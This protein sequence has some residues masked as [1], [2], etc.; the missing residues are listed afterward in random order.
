MDHFFISYSS[1]DG[2]ELAVKL[3]DSLVAGPPSVPI[4]IDVRHL[5]TGEDWDEQI[6]EAI[7]TC[8]GF[9]FVMT[10]DSVTPT[11]VCKNEWTRALKY[12]KPIL[13]LH[14]SPDAELPF[15]LGSRQF[16][17]F[18]SSFDTAIARLRNHLAWIDSAEGQ[19]VALQYRLA[20][21]QRDLPRASPEQRPRVEQDIADLTRQITQH[22][23]ALD[24]PKA[25]QQRVQ[26]SIEGGLASVRDAAPPK[27]AVERNRIINP[28]PLV[29]PGWF[30]DRLLETKMIGDFLKDDSLRLMTIVGRGGI[31]K[32]AVV[33]RLLRA[34]E[35]GR[36]P[37]DG[38]HWAVDGIVYLSA[39]RSHHRVTVP[40]LYA[41]LTRLLPA[42]VTKQLDT[43]HGSGA[44]TRTTVQALAE[45]FSSTKVVVLLD[46]FED[47]MAIETGRIKDVDVD[48]CLR[49]LL[50]LPPHGIKVIVTTRVALAEIAL[51]EPAR[52]RRLDLDTGL[53]HPFG[54]ALLREMDVDGK[55]GLREAPD[56]LLSSARER[57]RGYPRALEHLYGILSADRSSSLAELLADT[58]GL[59]P[60]R[61][62][63][64]L[65]GEAF[66]RLDPAAQR[67]VQALS[68]YSNPVPT[69]AVDFL[70]QPYPPAI[71]AGPTLSR[72]VNMQ[73]VKKDA[74]GFYLHQVDR[75]HA[76]ARLPQDGIFSRKDLQLRAADWFTMARKPYTT[77]SS[78]DDISAVLSEF[79]LRMACG[80]Y[81]RAAE[82]A[83]QLATYLSLWG[84]NRLLV[85]LLER[86]RETPV[87][88]FL[89]F[90]TNIFL[91]L[92]YERLSELDRA[93]ICQTTALRIA[94]ERQNKAEEL[95]A[96][97]N[98]GLLASRQGRKAEAVELLKQ[99]L[100]IAVET[101]S[102][103]SEAIALSSLAKEFRDVGNYIEALDY[104]NRA[105]AIDREHRRFENLSIGLQNLA[106]MFIELGRYDNA[107]RCCTESLH[108]G[109]LAHSRA[110]Q[111]A[112]LSSLGDLYLRTDRLDQAVD[113]FRQSVGIADDIELFQFQIGGRLDLS[114]VHLI[115]GNIEAARALLL[116]CLPWPQAEASWINYALGVVALMQGRREDAREKFLNELS[117]ADRLLTLSPKS[118]SYMGRRAMTLCGLACC[119]V[120]D[121]EEARQAYLACLSP[122]RRGD[123][124]Y[125]LLLLNLLSKTAGGGV[126]S[127][128]VQMLEEAKT[129]SAS[130]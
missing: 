43:V 35:S 118:L 98:L 6:V 59:L 108:F 94:R 53:E 54:E 90:A 49:A 88:A 89:A 128:I 2:K 123:I 40:D 10:M 76:L 99:A 93:N 79:E 68:V 50:D 21:A 18:T 117:T 15:R 7:R 73:F 45:A 46:N 36:L 115:R 110:T 112:A 78:I 69:A 120:R 130:T 37:D 34:L 26:H 56:H 116:E 77:W 13:P 31:G 28:P 61:V 4:W 113:A 75:D 124:T 23:Q 114:F 42:A 81:N 86:V 62:R 17:D 121:V 12:K 103:T 20:D 41:G 97:G 5:R 96:L 91:G 67:V 11:S 63:E 57:T 8:K 109:K 16:I 70:L 127:G 14:C 66:S 100:A 125:D 58:S 72:L 30:Q 105:I 29:A 24:D 104:F 22:Q 129:K 126:L 106:N 1:T 82:A 52:Q 33:C 39:A 64:V 92:A 102:V 85:G 25:A 47:V 38:G 101:G 32:T 119:G 19:L 84:H 80:D 65:V 44:D 48:E 55:V 87:E 60:E 3:A 71:E 9:L 83:R 95:D 51:V 74:A 111:A 107:E 122:A 27:P